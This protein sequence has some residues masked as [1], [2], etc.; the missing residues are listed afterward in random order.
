LSCSLTSIW[1]Y[2]SNAVYA[3]ASAM[4]RQICRLITSTCVRT[5]CRNYHCTLCDYYDVNN[6]DGWCVN[7][8]QPMPTFN[9][10]KTLHIDCTANFD[11]SAIVLDL[12]TGY[13][14]EI[15][16]EYPHLHDIL[17]FFLSARQ[18]RGLLMALYASYHKQR[19]II[20][21]HNLQCPHHDLCI[22]KIHWVLQFAQS[23]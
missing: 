18:A 20:H 14:L 10:S 21:Y 19:Y 5:T 4:F 2:S 6:L 3:I 1:F 17:L 11:A 23:T 9:G 15:N 12:F 16:L 7:H 13:I 8:C 22:T